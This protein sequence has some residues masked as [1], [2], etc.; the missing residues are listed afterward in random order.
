M[1]LHRSAQEHTQGYKRTPVRSDPQGWGCPLLKGPAGSAS[2]SPWQ[3]QPSPPTTVPLP[4]P[5]LRR[6]ALHWR[7]SVL[8]CWCWFSGEAEHSLYVCAFQFGIGPVPPIWNSWSFPTFQNALVYLFPPFLF[9]PPV[10][11]PF[12]PSRSV[13]FSRAG[14]PVGLWV[15]ALFHQPG[16]SVRGLFHFAS[17]CWLS[18]PHT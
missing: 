4:C 17:C 3:L 13:C 10:F 7:L 1:H 6:P 11:L 14:G 15:G 5:A 9:S 8:A 16:A 2:Q 18:G 12:S